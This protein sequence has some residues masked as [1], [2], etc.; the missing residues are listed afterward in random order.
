MKKATNLIPCAL[1]YQ[2][3]FINSPTATEINSMNNLNYKSVT[4]PTC[5]DDTH[6]ALT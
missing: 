3:S 4:Y 1:I 6:H 2:N 5:I